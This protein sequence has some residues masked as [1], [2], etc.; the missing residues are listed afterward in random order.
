MPFRYK[1]FRNITLTLFLSHVYESVDLLLHNHAV[2]LGT[3]GVKLQLCPALIAAT[4]AST[5]VMSTKSPTYNPCSGQSQVPNSSDKNSTRYSKF[6]SARNLCPVRFIRLA[7]YRKFNCVHLC[8]NP[9]DCF[10]SLRH[11]NVRDFCVLSSYVAL[12][13][14]FPSEPHRLD[15]CLYL[16]SL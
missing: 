12:S 3:A 5:S 1:T 9:L 10:T 16:F 15:I 2:A 4:L 14:K 11:I 8:V 7:F 6:G 13:P